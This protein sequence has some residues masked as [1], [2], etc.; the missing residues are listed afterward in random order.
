MGGLTWFAFFDYQVPDGTTAQVVLS[1]DGNTILAV[2]SDV[3]MP[4][5]LV[6]AQKLPHVI[7]DFMPGEGKPH[8]ILV[9]AV[10]LAKPAGLILL[11]EGKSRP[12]NQ[13]APPAG[14]I[15]ARTRDPE[16]IDRIKAICH[17]CDE[18]NVDAGS[19]LECGCSLRGRVESADGHCPLIPPKW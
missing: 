18:W 11:S 14:Q 12:D 17:G 1:R 13:A 9:P 4:L 19:C 2:R 10:S 5:M 15:A 3:K 6:D 8:Q 7:A 16:E